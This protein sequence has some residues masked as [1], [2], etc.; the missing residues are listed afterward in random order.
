MFRRISVLIALQFTAFV[1]L[2]FLVNGALF[3]IADFSTAKRQTHDRLLRTADYINDRVHSQ[4]GLQTSFLPP[5]V[6]DRIRIIGPNGEIIFNGGLFTN[7]PSLRT[8]PFV[9]ARIQNDDYTIYTSPLIGNDFSRG[10]VQIADIERLQFGDLPR[11]A[12]IYLLVSLAISLLTF[13][14]GLFFARRSLKPAEEMV[15]RLEQ[16]TQDASHELRTPIAALN[17]SLDLALKTKKYREGIQS[18]KDDLQEVSILVERLL[19]LA[20]LDT[21]S[22]EMKSI[23]IS[24]L[25]EALVARMKLL[26]K[27]KHVSIVTHI[28]T[29]I[30]VL[31]DESLIKQLITNLLTNAIKFSKPEGGEI[32]V[33]LTKYALSI[34][35]H[36]IGIAKEALPHIFDRFYQVE[37]SRT[38]DGY[39]LGLAL[40]KR[41][42][43]VHGWRLDV[44]SKEGEGTAFTL[45]YSASKKK[46]P[47]S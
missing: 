4:S 14:V 26:A 13:F 21:F 10:Y 45:H 29:D 42:A 11:R 5:E 18:A 40:V 2:L 43:D 44:R 20:R 23:D 38:K 37:T 41:I 9:E 8:D 27:K 7:V 34:Q 47:N 33:T 1:F 3:L 30:M 24:S 32:H 6:R 17:S 46:N 12:T 28:D 35:D 16:F 19:E 15:E 39:G 31:G 36:G 25:T 22:F